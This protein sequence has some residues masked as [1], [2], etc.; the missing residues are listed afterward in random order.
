MTLAAMIATALFAGTA[1]GPD[2]ALVGKIAGAGASL[3]MEIQKTM[4][5]KV[6][7][8]ADSRKTSAGFF[9]WAAS[10]SAPAGGLAG[11][12]AQ[13]IAPHL[14]AWEPIVG[15]AYIAKAPGD[16]IARAV[17]AG[18][19]ESIFI[20][21]PYA[22]QAAAQARQ[23]GQPVITAATVEVARAVDAAAVNSHPVD[24]AREAQLKAALADGKLSCRDLT[25]IEGG[26]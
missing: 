25:G 9:C 23:V 17:A 26:L 11:A 3:Q 14:A 6:M 5:P 16:V 19:P 21:V 15:A 12:M 4:L 22:E 1:P 13:A 10:D 18:L 24:E 2:A 8:L 7:A 20:L